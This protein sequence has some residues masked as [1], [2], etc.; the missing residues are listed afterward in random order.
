MCEEPS[1]SL[2]SGFCGALIHSTGPQPQVAR[3]TYVDNGGTGPRYYY[4]RVE[5]PDREVGLEFAD[6]AE[7]AFRLG[8]PMPHSS[9]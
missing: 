3:L 2:I 1:Q 5:Q 9:G 6:L 8:S 7:F 4:V